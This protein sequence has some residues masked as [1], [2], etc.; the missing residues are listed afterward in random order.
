MIPGLKDRKCYASLPVGGFFTPASR[1]LHSIK[2]Q[3]K[4]G[5]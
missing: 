4:Q 5:G 3:R 1:Y 2:N